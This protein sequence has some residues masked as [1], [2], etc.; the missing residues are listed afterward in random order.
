MEPREREEFER[1][2]GLSKE[3]VEQIYLNT[4]LWKVHGIESYQAE[5]I[6]QKDTLIEELN[7]YFPLP[8]MNIFAYSPPEQ[9][10]R[11]RGRYSPLKG[12]PLKGGKRN[13]RRGRQGRSHTS[14]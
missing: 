4:L 8:V 10:T 9:K 7:E 5:A 3:L 12:S 2:Y 14:R 1:S 6:Q 13:T 11:K